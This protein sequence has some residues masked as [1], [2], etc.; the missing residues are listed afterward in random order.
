VPNLIEIGSRK[1]DRALV[2]APC[3]K[4]N[5]LGQTHVIMVIIDTV[6]FNVSSEAEENVEHRAPGI[7]QQSDSVLS[8]LR[9]E[10]KERVGHLKHNTE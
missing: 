1:R 5:E 6:V 7:I 8:D 4:R 3:G 10:A 9:D 2:V